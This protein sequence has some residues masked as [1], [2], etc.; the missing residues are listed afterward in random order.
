MMITPTAVNTICW[1]I[2]IT[3][4]ANIISIVS[5]NDTVQYGDFTC[6]HTKTVCKSIIPVT[7]IHIPNITLKNAN[8]ESDDKQNYYTK[9]YRYKCNC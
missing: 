6:F 2:S 1:F 4:P 3:I 8:I 5:S 9:Y 7:M